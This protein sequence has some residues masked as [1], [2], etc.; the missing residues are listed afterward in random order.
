V[1]TRT[2]YERLGG[3]SGAL[4]SQLDLL[5][6][7]L[8]AEQQKQGQRLLVGLVDI[9]EDIT[10][11][12]RRRGWVDRLRPEGSLPA[13]A[14]DVVL[15]TLVAHRL[16]VR[17]QAEGDADLGSSG[18]VEI[19]HEALIR[20]WRRLQLWLRNDR[21]DTELFREL[22]KLASAWSASPNEKKRRL[23]YLPAGSK[24]EDFEDL[25]RRVGPFSSAIARCLAAAR[26]RREQG[27][28]RVQVIIAA[29]T[30]SVLFLSAL[31]INA[32]AQWRMAELRLRGE[33]TALGY[34][35]T[36]S[37]ALGSGDIT[38][39][40]SAGQNTLDVVPQ[41]TYIVVRDGDGQTL[42]EL[43]KPELRLMGVRTRDIPSIQ[44]PSASLVATQNLET[45]GIQLLAVEAPVFFQR[46]SRTDAPLTLAT[47]SETLP[48]PKRIGAACIGFRVGSFQESAATL[49]L[50]L[51]LLGGAVTAYALARLAIHLVRR[52]I[53]G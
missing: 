48:D 12:T 31:S 11:S 22:E 47:L 42:V 52:F 28:L 2:A 41:L 25:E 38:S 18:W 53:R 4:S 1:L 3:L 46:D 17:G 44:V 39:I 7:R 27:K 34:A 45:H 23:K 19:A 21:A 26:A 29:L 15:E 30:A 40:A 36:V 16:L 6:D 5:W 50:L 37:D 10:L 43:F 32:L 49:T 33:A 9:A 24:L 35:G 51:N 8:P 14:F 20:R 13:A